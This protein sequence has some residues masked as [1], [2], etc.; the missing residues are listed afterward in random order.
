MSTFENMWREACAI[1]LKQEYTA[2]DQLDINEQPTKSLEPE[3]ISIL[4]NRMLSLPTEYLD[5]L[6]LY[7]CFGFSISDI[8]TLEDLEDSSNADSTASTSSTRLLP[9]SV[10]KEPAFIIRTGM[11]TV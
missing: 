6:F 10:N 3:L 4:A 5:L 2:L 11:S 9:T 1:S 7:Y 8:E